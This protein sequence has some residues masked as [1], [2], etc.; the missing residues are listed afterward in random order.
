MIKSLGLRLMTT[1]DLPFADHLRT[2]EGWNQTLEDWQRFLTTEPA[3]CFVALRNG[4]P[5]GT[6]VTT[7]Y[8]SE[9]A[10]IGMLLVHPDYR[11]RGIGKTLLEGCIK[12]L[13]ERK[14]RCIK[15]DASC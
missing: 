14:V 11:S 5:V 1:G 9:L 4:V 3:G 13:Q 12:Y 6:I 7:V 2:L 8:G 15:L 10:W